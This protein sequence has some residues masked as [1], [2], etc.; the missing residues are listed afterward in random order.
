M[1]HVMLDLETWGVRPGC[2]LRSIGAVEFDLEGMVG[3]TFYANIDDESCLQAGLTID[4]A[5][6]EWWSKQSAEVQQALIAGKEP[7]SVVVESFHRWF[8]EKG[9]L[10]VWSQGGNFDEPLWAA[11]AKAVNSALPWKFWNTRCTRTAYHLANF[12]PPS[13]PRQGQHHNALD[14]A[15]FQVHCIQESFRLIERR[16][17]PASND[18]YMAFNRTMAP[19]ARTSGGTESLGE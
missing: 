12:D 19:D 6:R 3:Q 1:H 9:A 4:P 15:V 7:L 10:Y 14:D 11:A 17:K 18:W 5:T 8:Q 2:A 13:M 16:A